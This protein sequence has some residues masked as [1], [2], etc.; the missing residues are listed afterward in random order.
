M[1]THDFEAKAEA[2]V[3][4]RRREAGEP[5]RE[6]VRP[7]DAASSSSGPLSAARLLALQSTHGNR[8][9]QRVVERARDDEP[10]LAP[11]TARAI[12]GARGGG[13]ALDGEVRG[14]MEEAFGADFEGVRVHTDEKSD[15]LNRELRAR[16]FTTGED[17]FFRRGQ[18]DPGSS[19]GRELLAHELAHVVQQSGA[20]VQAKLTLGPAGDRFEQEADRAAREVVRM[21]SR[22]DSG[23]VQRMEDDLEDEES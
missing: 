20:P 8:F 13:R 10:E 14:R 9:V 6:T 18:Y 4:P 7:P 2:D 1:K 17:V 22:T 5:S 15:D 23:P 11:E 16:A 19:T 21:E 12:A 3:R